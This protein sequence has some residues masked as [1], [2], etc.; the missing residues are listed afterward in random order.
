MKYGL[1]RDE[2]L[3][4]QTDFRRVYERRCSAAD[5]WLVVYGCPNGLPH[6]RVGL[7]VGRKWGRAPTRNRIRR[8]YREAFRL[9]KSELPS[10]LDFIL[11]PRRAVR[12]TLEQVKHSLRQL[13]EQVVKQLTR[14]ARPQA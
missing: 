1:S 2:R 4:R 12:L 11:I 6:S 3:R 5:E 14:S 13:T 10:G 7:S 8:L 9:S